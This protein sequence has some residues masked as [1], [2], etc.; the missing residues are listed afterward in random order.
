MEITTASLEI[1]IIR[2]LRVLPFLPRGLSLRRFSVSFLVWWLPGLQRRRSTISS[3]L[4]RI[5][6][7]VT[8]HPL[9]SCYEKAQRFV[10]EF[11]IHIRLRC[12]YKK[13]NEIEQT[14]SFFLCLF[15]VIGAVFF[16]SGTVLGTVFGFFWCFG[17]SVCFLFLYGRFFDRRGDSLLLDGGGGSGGGFSVWSKININIR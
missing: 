2:L 11:A 1:Y 8:I 14:F 4:G 15:T 7:C 9:S 13:N 12:D 17:C 5:L 16:R 10:R 3:L 6:K